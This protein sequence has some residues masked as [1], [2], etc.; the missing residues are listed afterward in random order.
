MDAACREHDVAHSQS[1]DID[2]RHQADKIL[3]EKAWQRVKSKY[4]D[5]KERANTWFV[6]NAMKAKEEFG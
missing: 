3:A 4:R 5:H 6:T 1:K 2:T